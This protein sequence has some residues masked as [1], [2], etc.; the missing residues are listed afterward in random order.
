[1]LFKVM[2]QLLDLLHGMIYEYL[3]LI[4]SKYNV[5]GAIPQET[6]RIISPIIAELY[7]L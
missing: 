3:D 7:P 5:W 2:L 4:F 6:Q 1:M